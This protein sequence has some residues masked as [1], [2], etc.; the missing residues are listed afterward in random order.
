MGWLLETLARHGRLALVA[1]LVA[2]LALPSVALAL[3]PWLAHLVALLLF[4]TA[5]RIGPTETW[6]G[7]R[8]GRGALRMVLILQ[9]ALPLAVM[10][11]LALA[12]LLDTPVA[13]A[14]LLMLSAPALTGSPNLSL[15]LG[16]KPEPAFRLLILGTALVPLTMLPVFWLLPQLGDFGAAVWG[17][18]RLLAVIAVAVALGFV[19]RHRWI[20]TPTQTRQVDGAMTLA[21]V[22]IVVGLMSALRPALE[23]RPLDA[24]GWM[25]LV[26][27][28]NFGLQAVTYHASRS[29]GHRHEA[30]PFAIIAGN[31]NV[32]LFL[33]TLPAAQVEPLLLFL[34]CYQLPMYLTPLLMRRFYTRA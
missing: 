4:L 7:L 30:V 2:G 17:A 26:F 21:L 20:P 28:V 3:K 24:L 14:L 31:R 34:G 8:Q 13:L 15:L 19:L 25:L 1:G 16:A 18:L 29:L 33:V 10:A 9:L 12:G 27:V 22:V 11:L 32:A 23:A 5:L 6:R